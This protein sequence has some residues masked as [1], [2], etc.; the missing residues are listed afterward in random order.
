MGV[1]CWMDNTDRMGERPIPELLLH[2]AAPAIT[3]LVV[4][5][6]YNIVDRI[7]VGHAVGPDGIAAITVSFP[8]MMFAMSYCI[9]VGVGSSSLISI[10][11]GRQ[12]TERAGKVL[13]N[14]ILLLVAGTLL[15]VLVGARFLERILM[16]SGASRSLLPFSKVYLTII[17][18]GIPFSNISMGFNYF[19]RAEGRPDYAMFTLII[20]AVLNIILDWL[21]IMVFS[22]GIAGA[23]LATV[24]A[25]MAASFWVISFYLF[26]RGN[27]RIGWRSLAPMIKIIG[28]I[29]VIGASPFLM[30]V[31]FTFILVLMNRVIR[32]YGGDMGISAVGIFFSLDSLLFLPVLGIGEGLQPLVGYNYGARIYSRVIHTVKLALIAAIGFF[33]LSFTVIMVFPYPLVHLFNTTS[34]D[35]IKLT[36]RGMRLGYMGLPV[37]AV[38]IVASYTLQSLGKARESLIL[39]ITRQ[40]VFFLPC[41]IFLPKLVGL[42]GV[43]LSLPAS[44]VMGGILGGFILRGEMRK[45]KNK[46]KSLFEEISAGRDTN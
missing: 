11:L 36:V 39:N 22:M 13:G 46:E 27:I 8:F 2:F 34:E 42:D 6:L 28:K 1:V 17:L 29:I 20:G 14:G 24:I 3:G 35:L 44:D 21:L 18:W 4:N 19:I 25:Q 30:E 41:L 40:F 37:A 7:F 16:L 15:Y 26:R 31:T 45:M 9:L 43:W 10:S 23:A 32:T 12:D 38:G 33:L 5:A